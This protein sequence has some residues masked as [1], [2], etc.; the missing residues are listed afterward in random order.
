MLMMY[1]FT[2]LLLNEN[3]VLN[4]LQLLPPEKS[5]LNTA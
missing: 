2:A 5:I 4:Q 1:L 3:N